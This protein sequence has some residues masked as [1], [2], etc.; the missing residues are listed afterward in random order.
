MSQS[1]WSRSTKSHLGNFVDDRTLSFTRSLRCTKI[2]G[3]MRIPYAAGQLFKHA[4]L[5][6]EKLWS[7]LGSHGAGRF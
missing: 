4:S 7:V 1:E 5:Q 3:I 6:S 2:K